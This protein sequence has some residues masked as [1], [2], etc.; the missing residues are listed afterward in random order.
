[1]SGAG[2]QSFSRGVPIGPVPA[3]PSIL[4][5][6]VVLALLALVLAGCGG[7]LGDS[8][9]THQWF[10]MDTDFS[11]T[12]YRIRESRAAA[13]PDSAFRLLEAESRRLEIVFSDYLPFSA[14]ARIRGRAGDTVAAPAPELVEVL[15][16]AER[17]A[18]ESG[19]LFDVTLH[20]LKAAWGLA[21]GDSG[22]VPTD[23][24]VA[25]AL[26][27]NPAFGSGPEDH[28]ALF[29]PFKV[30][31]KDRVVLL[32]DSVLLDLGGIAK[33]YAVD[34]L[35]ALLDTLGYRTHLVQAGG[36]MRVSGFKPGGPWRIGI[37][38]P[39]R[40]DT[41]AGTLRLEDAR[42][43]STSGDYE[44]SFVE[45][46]VRYHHVFDPRTG[47]PAGPWCSVTVLASASLWADALTEPLFILG[48]SRGRA[49]L[50][51]HGAEA[52]WIRPEGAGLCAVATPGLAGRYA[53]PGI[54][55][56]HDP[57]T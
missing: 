17:A 57:G 47:R 20:D 11:A 4:A 44:R 1:M 8:R 48:P 42:A 43:V 23:S 33:G 25:A 37:R 30:V 28:P 29:P 54:P 32:R 2:D 46:G 35:H 52:L 26:R 51:K 31:G 40:P 18:R 5:P 6:L 13:D 45:G 12:L 41:L 21:S 49:L 38:H 15:R 19:G 36:D 24:A 56:C 7:R 9:A 50:A 55:E 14:L 22:R 39:R 10:A 3:L 34:R 53:L 16:A 27:G